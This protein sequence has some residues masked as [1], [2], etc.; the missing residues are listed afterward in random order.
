MPTL[1][2]FAS[3]DAFNLASLTA[4]VNDLAFTPTMIREL[5][6]FEER[7]VA[8]VTA[9][10]EE[11][12]ETISLISPKPRNAPGTVADADKRVVNHIGIP[13]IP[14][15]ATIM[16][17]EVQGIREFGSENTARPLQSAI[18]DRLAK[19]RRQIDYT[20]EYHRLLAL[21]GSYMGAGG[22]V[23]SAYTLFGGSRDSVDF[24]LGTTSTPIEQKCMDVLGHIEDGL[25]GASYTG[26]HVL[27]SPS[28]WK[29]FI[30]HQ[31]YKKYFQNTSRS[32]EPV[33]SVRGAREFCDFV[34]H[35]YRG[36]SS[37]Q[38]ADGKAYAFPV[39]VP[40]MY[41]TRFA[42]ANYS[43]AV[44]TEGLPYYA[45]AEPLPFGKGMDME[46]QSNPLNICTRPT[47]LV[48]L[49]TSN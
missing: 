3:D 44:N 17:D 26:V 14:Q 35:R 30:S 10:I 40:D 36:S 24:V 47:A 9:L 12:N 39:G 8:S 42:P 22:S 28:F 27:C 46:V 21:T 20:I 11:L 15:R 38:V 23:L 32:L 19:M 31:E 29:K 34:F 37:V 7:G 48:E 13:H 49:T 2:P 18:N 25:G 33:T 41:L 6:V 45:K 5:G 43:E 16:A 1:N 4:A